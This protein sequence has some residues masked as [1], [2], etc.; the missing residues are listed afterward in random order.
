MNKRIRVQ[1][2]G[3]Y[4]DKIR[5][6]LNRAGIYTEDALRGGNPL[7]FVPLT[8]RNK[9]DNVV[10]SKN[11]RNINNKVTQLTL[12][13]NLDEYLSHDENI[14]KSNTTS[15]GMT[16]RYKNTSSYIIVCNTNLVYPLYLYKNNYYSDTAKNNEFREYLRQE[17]AVNISSSLCFNDIRDCFD[18]Y[19][20]I[21]LKEYD[22][23]H[24]LLIKTSPSLWYF[25]QGTFKLFDNSILNLRKFIIEADNYFIEKTGCVVINTFEKFVPD[26]LLKESYLPCAFYPDFAYDELSADIITAIHDTEN[27]SHAI[28]QDIKNSI[29]S[30]KD[31]HS[32]KK[33]EFLQFLVKKNDDDSYLSIEDIDYIEKYVDTNIIGTDELIGIFML[34]TRTF[35]HNCFGKIA[36]KLLQNKNVSVV[37]QSLRR[38]KENEEFL[39]RYSYFQGNIPKN[40]DA[41]IRI[42]NQYILGIL[43][44]QNI[45]FQLFQFSHNTVDEEKVLD[46][47]Y[48]CFINEAEALCKSIK[49]YVQRAKRGAGNQPIK[50]KYE[51][52]ERFK[53]SLFIL[54]YEHLLNNEPFL[55][56]M[57]EVATKDFC[58]RTNL[59]FLFREKT[60]II[61][62]RGGLADQMS[63]YFM[64]K[65]IQYEGADIYYDDIPAR[66]IN[67]DHVGYEL[68]KVITEDIS[69]RCF[70]NI[71]SGELVKQFDNHEME[72]PDVLFEAGVY[73]LLAVTDMHLFYCC[74]YKKASRML[75]V[76]KPGHEDESIRCFVRG[77]GS[78]LLYYY[79]L[80][81]PEFFMLHYPLNLNQLCKFP[82]FE[83][84]V[85][86]RLQQEMSHCIVIGVHIRRGDYILLKQ[87]G[88]TNP[89]YYKE[90]IQKVLNIPEYS[91]ARVL[92]FSDDIPWC[93]EHAKSLG[94]LQVNKEKLTYISH[95]KG[96]D[97]F[98]D[99]Q[100]LTLCNVIIAQQ[101]GFAKTAFL[102]SDKSEMF[103]TPDN[104]DRELFNKIGR[105][106]KYAITLK[107]CVL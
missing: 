82:D 60:R 64:S 3:N 6:S 37:A 32:P 77:F 5:Y 59:E 76:I 7:G 98:R 1:I 85:N 48:C 50:L 38:Y 81:R 103:I 20:E 10:F 13:K 100:L 88:E 102:L 30:E 53:Q 35:P 94:L 14:F 101:G 55:I 12:N 58:V 51:S 73:N 17:G 61:K 79:C 52:E 65:C 99:M 11:I 25:D 4:L 42:N 84:D 43:P 19:I 23:E 86:L 71:L 56:G 106:N 70:S 87:L 75:F 18:K 74:G 21:I 34:A 95:N 107:N 24:I 63:L 97:S 8:G 69:E 90:A 68:D 62:I 78:N 89:T 16:V 45:P 104:R 80:I 15:Y 22:S 26:G 105:G 67:A 36:V 40:H 33:E 44:E 41:Y 93:R 92:V 9:H 31:V 72:L 54:D 96:E 49:F 29:I 27:R 28:G 57:E 2:I 91:E 46:N 39:S 66:S 83:D 47:G